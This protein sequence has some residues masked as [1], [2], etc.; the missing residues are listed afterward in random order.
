MEY[1]RLQL[2]N[3]QFIMKGSLCGEKK[4]FPEAEPLQGFQGSEE[5]IDHL[6]TSPSALTVQNGK[7]QLC[8]NPPVAEKQVAVLHSKLGAHILLSMY[9]KCLK[10]RNG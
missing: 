4:Q 7:F 6:T 1:V 5:N 9:I 2:F 3:H 8:H 10:K